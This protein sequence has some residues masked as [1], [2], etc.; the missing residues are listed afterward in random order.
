MITA[1]AGAIIGTVLPLIIVISVDLNQAH[2]KDT[3]H[4]AYYR[5]ENNVQHRL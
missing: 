2:D 1:T 3:K 4:A 5:S